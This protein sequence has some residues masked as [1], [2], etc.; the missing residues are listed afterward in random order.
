MEAVY[1][2]G[3]Q[4]NVVSSTINCNGQTI[5]TPPTN[6]ANSSNLSATLTG[7]SST[8]NFAYLGAKS[9]FEMD[10]SSSANFGSDIYYKFADSTATPIT[11]TNPTY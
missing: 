11:I 4:S 8:F 6:A 1:T 5:P 2:G 7:T 10:M 9:H 3:V